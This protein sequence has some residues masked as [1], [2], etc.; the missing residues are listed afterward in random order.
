MTRGAACIAGGALALLLVACAPLPPA[1]PAAPQDAHRL[2]LIGTA[3]LPSGTEFLG[4][5]VG[6]LSGIDYDSVH[7]RYL[8]ISDDRSEHQSARAY[9]A[10]LRYTADALAAPELTGVITLRHASGEPFA[11]ARRPRPGMDVPDAEAVRWR[12][13]GATFLW[14]SEGDFARGFGP[15]LRESHADGAPVR[16]IPL[17]A[18]FQP[19][20][21]HGPRGNAT[22]EG[23]ALA[24]GGRT[25]WLAMEAAWKQD[26]PPPTPATAGAPVRFTA[27]DVAS[28]QPLRQI[29]YVPDA[30][31]RPRRLPWGPQ[32]N[33]VSEVLADGPH[34]LLVLERAYSAGA[35]F[36]ARLYRVDTREGDDTLALDRLV[37]GNHTPVPK[38]LVADFEALGVTPLDNLE[39]MAWGAP[40]PGSSGNTR[41]LVFVSD[42]NFNPAQATQF[43]AAAYL[44]PG[45]AR[46]PRCAR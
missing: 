3:A 24:P 28:G 25:A 23:L 19:A 41:V 8:L 38:A 17:P 4:T 1:A 26:G 21:D 2:C 5:T 18:S 35:G 29:A 36:S 42:D 9:T 39:G 40:L 6:G 46:P 14:T 44:E 7:D 20:A 27:I 30:V 11:P 22:L 13:G 33:G 43:I 10:R 15:Q 45:A 31:P 32:V 12:P 34:H 37:R 16:D